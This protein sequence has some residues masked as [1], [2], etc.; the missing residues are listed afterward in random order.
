MMLTIAV[1][2]IDFGS[3]KIREDNAKKRRS[4]HHTGPSLWRSNRVGRH[5]KGT[6]KDLLIPIIA[7]I[8]LLRHQV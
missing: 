5:W 4:V 7:L 1:L 8:I 3:M 2:N 6:V